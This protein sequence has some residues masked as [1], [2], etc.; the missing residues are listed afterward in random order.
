MLIRVKSAMAELFPEPGLPVR[1]DERLERHPGT[2][3]LLC[4]ETPGFAS[5]KNQRFVKGQ[6]GWTMDEFISVTVLSR[7][8]ERQ[9]DF[10]G[11]LSKF[12]T[13][14]LRNRLSAFEKVYAEATAFEEQ[15]DRWSRKYLAEETVLDILVA[16]LTAASVDFAPI[17]HNE[18]YS[19]YEAVSPEWMQIEH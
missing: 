6:G 3:L 19:R 17:D 7:P 8:G 11:R 5:K 10:S 2:F 12:W 14:M 15:T 1:Q 9:A 18:V 4:T 16:E 13:H